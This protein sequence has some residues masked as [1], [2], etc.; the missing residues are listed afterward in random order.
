MTALVIA[1]AIFIFLVVLTYAWGV[2]NP[3]PRVG[4]RRDGVTRRHEERELL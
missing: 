4:D 1:I 3:G 2:R